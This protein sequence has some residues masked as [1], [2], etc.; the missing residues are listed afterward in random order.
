MEIVQ[1]D[2]MTRTFQAAAA[3]GLLDPDDTTVVFLDWAVLDDRIE[4]LQNAF[5][6]TTLHAIAIKTNP[7]TAVLRYLVDQPVGLEA[8]SLGELL[9]A[10]NAG[11]TTDRLV[12]DSPA[13]TA[14]EI[15]QL[16]QQM[17]GL[18]VNADSLQELERYPDHPTGLRLGL[19]INPLI[20]SNSLNYMSVGS[21]Q[22][23]FGEP[24]SN[25]EQIIQ[26]CTGRAE[27]DCLHVHIGSQVADLEPTVRAIRNVCDLAVEINQRADGNPITTLDIGGGFPVNYSG[28]PFRIETYTEAL[29]QGCPR[30]FDG[31]FQLVTE[32]GRYVY[33]NTCWAATRIEYVKPFPGGTNLITHAGADL[34][35]RE[36]YNPGDWFHHL[37]IVDAHGRPRSGDSTRTSV[38]GPLCFGGDFIARDVELPVAQPGDWLIV[39]DVGANSFSLWSRHCSRP[40][41]KVISCR[42]DGQELAIAKHRE[43]F[44]SIIQFWS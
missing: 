14:R 43:S 35:L 27:L 36:C 20:E 42:R 32:F 12:F 24:I 7:L 13:K 19:R 37:H 8:A 1:A 21:P 6:D 28:E 18:R 15:D 10:Q 29:Q 40:F 38:A 9:L 31:S 17:N 2:N 33:A 44:E 16:Q 22:S 41:P 30:L 23:K 34:F 25:R 39:S 26:A 5:P 11:F 4:R 3:A